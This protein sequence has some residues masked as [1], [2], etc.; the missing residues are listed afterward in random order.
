M[1]EYVCSGAMMKCSNGL[2]PSTLMVLP[3]NRVLNNNQPQANIMDHKPM[4]NVMPFGMCRSLLNP[5]VA[6]ATA[7]AWGTLTPMPCI[8][9]TPAPW[10]PGK[11][12]SLVANKPALIKSSKLLCTYAGMIS[13]TTP[14]QFNFKDGARPK[15]AKIQNIPGLKSTG[16]TLQIISTAKNE[17]PVNKE[18]QIDVFHN[19]FDAQKLE[20]DNAL[21]GEII[22]N[23]NLFS[24]ESTKSYG[25]SHNPAASIDGDYS[26]LNAVAYA[27][28][29]VGDDGDRVGFAFNAALKAS[30]VEGS[31]SGK[32]EIPIPF[33]DWSIGLNLKGS[34]DAASI[35]G[36]IGA[37]GFYSKK[38]QRVYLGASGSLAKK[39]GLGLDIEIS[40]GKKYKH[41]T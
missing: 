22:G 16:N 27:N 4:V 2:A 15:T 31:V 19:D 7:A 17:I 38:R 29:F 11:L 12:N 24:G 14:G 10:F 30:V 39:L 18:Y 8:P 25:N 32:T 5:A 28:G 21:G 37:K 6:A 35:G 36:S 23:V 40:I 26:V 3:V 33:T 41:S 34:G 13:F 20:A 9:N 1:P